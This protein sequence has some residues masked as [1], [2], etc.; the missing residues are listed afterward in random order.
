[1]TSR[2]PPVGSVISIQ[3]PNPKQPRPRAAK[4]SGTLTPI[5]N[6]PDI[7]SAPKAI[8]AAEMTL[9]PA[10]ARALRSAPAQA[11]TAAKLGTASRPPAR[12]SPKRSTMTCGIRRGSSV[13]APC[14]AR[15]WVTAQMSIRNA[16][17]SKVPRAA[18]SIVARPPDSQAAIRE[19]MAMPKQKMTSASVAVSFVPPSSCW[20]IDGIMASA[21]AP[22]SQ[23]QL[24]ARLARQMRWSSRRSRTSPAVEAKILRWTR[25]SGGRGLPGGRNE[26]GGEPAEDREGHDRHG[27]NIV[28]GGK[29]RGK[30]AGDCAA[31]DRH[32][33]RA[34]DQGI[35][36]GQLLPRQVVW[37]DAVFDR[38]EQ[39]RQRAEGKQCHEQDRD[40]LQ[41]EADDRDDGGAKLRQLDPLG[42]IGLVE[43]IRQFATEPREEEEGCD[44]EGA[45]QGD[46]RI[47]SMRRRTM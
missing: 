25:R 22:T 40:A 5:A 20:T 45:G 23:N 11:W 37:Q 7:I 36:L 3:P 19:P 31:D 12:D 1:M 46:E 39:G 35:G 6:R 27:Q 17:I 14:G 16:P 43:P 33:G 34:L 44:E 38:A 24:E 32:E 4:S 8:A 42:E 21:M 10:T 30:T 41:Q 9:T 18:G 26:P 28:A 15:P 47:R 13:G 2:R 29:G